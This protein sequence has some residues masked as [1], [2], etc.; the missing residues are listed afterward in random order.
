M[1]FPLPKILIVLLAAALLVLPVPAA[2]PALDPL[3]PPALYAQTAVL[4]DADTGQVLWG[5]EMHRRMYPASLT[6]MVTLLLA[7]EQ[8]NPADLV[9]V[10]AE[11]VDTMPA[12]A[13][14]IALTYDE[15]LTLEQLTYAMM[16]ESANDAA[17]A[18]AVHLSGSVRAFAEQMNQK[19]QALGAG[20]SH[21]TNPHGLPEPD[22]YTTAYDMA[23]FTR[24]AYAYPQFRALAGCKLYEIPPTN[25]Q[26]GTRRLLNKQYMFNGQDPYPGA[27]AGKTGWTE[28][29]GHT[30]ITVAQRNGITLIC[31][32]MKPSGVADGEFVDS[33]ALLDYG[34]EQF[35]RVTLSP[36]QVPAV[37]LSEGILK[38]A[39]EMTVLL[40]KAVQPEDLQLEV[41]MDSQ[42]GTGYV[43]A[44]APAWAGAYMTDLELGRFPTTLAP[45][46]VVIDAAA[47]RRERWAARLDAFAEKVLAALPYVA[48]VIA[49]PLLLYWI[50]HLLAQLMQDVKERQRKH[51]EAVNAKRMEAA[52]RRLAV[53]QM[54]QRRAAEKA[55]Q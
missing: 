38:P 15:Q 51:K 17:S 50:I 18:I 43:T 54:Q 11:A 9:T 36:E 25:K 6:K 8:G 52:R 1:R 44:K 16:V 14:H 37:A 30:L 39:G 32:V 13:T 53:K 24:A 28:E 29:A 42:D 35:R 27:F 22:H 12:V 21:F 49:V 41:H 55:K 7:M 34:F 31:V 26:E 20:G 19:A 45:A 5:K 3:E 46:P 23:L 4:M 33:T 2:E 47:Q 10:T 40:P 48:I